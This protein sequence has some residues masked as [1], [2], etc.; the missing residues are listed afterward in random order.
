MNINARLI[1]AL[2]ILVILAG[3]LIFFEN[4]SYVGESEL[5]QYSNRIFGP[6]K[7]IDADSIIIEGAIG[8]WAEEGSLTENKTVE[9]SITSET[10]FTK[11]AIIIT[12]DTKPGEVFYP[13]TK[14]ITGA[15]EDLFLGMAIGITSEENLFGVEKAT[16]L[17]VIY[18]TIEKQN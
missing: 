7:D 3:V 4:R 2:A 5:G 14:E 11:K 15:L 18:E 8:G 12:G 17:E 1:A 6:I 10:K 16:A 9:F 13:E